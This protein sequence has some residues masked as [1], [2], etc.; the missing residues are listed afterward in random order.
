[1]CSTAEEPSRVYGGQKGELS[2][3]P[4]SCVEEVM[5]PELSHELL[6]QQCDCGSIKPVITLKANTA[7]QLRSCPVTFHSVVLLRLTQHSFGKC[8]SL[9]ELGC[10][11]MSEST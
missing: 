2:T 8:C 3:E 4:E 9:T 7:A 5:L 10:V 6:S 1:M 11:Q